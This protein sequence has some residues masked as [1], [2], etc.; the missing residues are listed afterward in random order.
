MY[1]IISKIIVGRLSPILQRI[2]SHFQN[3]FTPDRSIHDNILIPKE[4]LNTFHKSQNKTGWT[5]SSQTRHGK[6]YDRIEWNFLWA[7]L[8]DFSFPDVWIS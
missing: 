5:H 7:T 1:K 3:A 8:K 4:I 2:I 6:T